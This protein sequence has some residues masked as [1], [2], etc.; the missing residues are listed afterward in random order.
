MR[1]SEEKV[2]SARDQFDRLLKQLGSVVVAESLGVD[3]EELARIRSGAAPLEGGVRERLGALAESMGA[4]VDWWGA[5][6]GEA[7][8]VEL[9]EGGEG[10]GMGSIRQSSVCSTLKTR[11]DRSMG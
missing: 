9:P 2:V 8:G 5:S 6:G 10:E 11:W 1:E 3:V 7:L 4:A